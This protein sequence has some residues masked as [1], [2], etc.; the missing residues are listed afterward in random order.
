[1]FDRGCNCEVTSVDNSQPCTVPTI[2]LVYYTS[3]V[4]PLLPA[5]LTVPYSYLTTPT[6]ASSGYSEATG[7]HAV[8]DFCDRRQ[9]ISGTTAHIH[10]EN[11][12]KHVKNK[13][14]TSPHHLKQRLYF[15]NAFT[16]MVEA[17]ERQ[18]SIELAKQRWNL[19]N[20]HYKTLHKGQFIALYFMSICYI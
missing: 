12:D 18:I 5:E 14:Q 13:Y 17:S 3:Q 9:A 19:I 1:L 16:H 4:Q 11:T 10:Y 20:T 15:G 7:S 2:L 8:I 6:S